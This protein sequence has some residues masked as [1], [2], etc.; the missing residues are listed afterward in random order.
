MPAAGEL[1]AAQS[2]VR[3]ACD[4][5]T[6]PTPEALNRCQEALERAVSEL[7]DFRSHC[8]EHQGAWSVACGLR[9]EVLRAARLLHSLAGFYRGW[10]RI[11]GTMSGGYTASGDPAPPA[12]T[13]RLCCRG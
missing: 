12:R 11:L 5:L 6:A 4:L 2:E 13:G 8:G 9:A 10:E 7:V 3:R 1:G